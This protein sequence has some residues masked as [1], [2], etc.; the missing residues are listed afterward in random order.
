MQVATTVDQPG[1][2]V[3]AVDQFG[4]TYASYAGTV[5]FTSSDA[6]ATLPAAF[7]YGNADAGSHTIDIQFR[8]PMMGDGTVSGADVAEVT[9]GCVWLSFFAG[10]GGMSLVHEVLSQADVDWS[11]HLAEVRRLVA[12]VQSRVESL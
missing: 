8:Y 7:T 10:S 12:E 4:V 2:T 5:H 9:I 6:Q 3:T 1:V 11:S